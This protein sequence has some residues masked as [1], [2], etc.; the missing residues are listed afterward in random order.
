[1]P[2]PLGYFNQNDPTTDPLSWLHKS[3]TEVEP[4]TSLFN[5]AA[6]PATSLS[7]AHSSSDPPLGCNSSLA[8]AMRRRCFA[9]P[10]SSSRCVP[11][12]SADHAWP[13]HRHQESREFALILARGTVSPGTDS[14]R[15]Q[16][17]A[18]GENT[19]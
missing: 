16:D 12:H 10:L 5:A 2:K 13:R 17:S 3:F 15:A 1:M 7:L 6:Q 14:D 8:T 9:W 4:F 18:E 19:P 11:G